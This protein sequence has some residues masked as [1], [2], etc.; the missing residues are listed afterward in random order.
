MPHYVLDYDRVSRQCDGRVCRQLSGGHT[1]IPCIRCNET[2]KFRDL[3]GVARDLDAAAMVT[4][5]YI[6]TRR[7]PSGWEM[8]RPAD[9]R[10]T[11]LFFVFNDAGT[12]GFLRF[13]LAR[14]DKDD[15]RKYAAA[16]GLGVLTSPTVRISALYQTVITQAL[17]SSY[18][19]I[20]ICPAKLSTS[21]AM[22]WVSTRACC[23]TQW[24]APRAGH[25]HGRPAFRSHRCRRAP[26]GGGPAHG[27]GSR[28][29]STGRSQLAGR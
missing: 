22:F 26:R 5:H 9:W 8:L 16:L 18:S 1:P 14:L 12:V 3:L 13:P 7:G 23:T 4:G 28:S 20:A 29:Y 10:A 15:I 21:R 19:L 17:S 27:F 11:S 25:S 2:V 24:P 6:A